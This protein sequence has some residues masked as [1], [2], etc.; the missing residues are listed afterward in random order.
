[1]A[2]YVWNAMK[3]QA[4]AYDILPPTTATIDYAI[5]LEKLSANEQFF[6]DAETVI[7]LSNIQLRL[8]QVFFL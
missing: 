3:L 4:L 7:R 5:G 1:M 6:V 2:I 8:Y